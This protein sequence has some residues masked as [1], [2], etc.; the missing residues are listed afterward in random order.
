MKQINKIK[1]FE[2]IK[3]YY[4]ITTCGKIIS[5]N[6][7]TKIL[8]GRLKKNGYEFIGLS[9]VDG[10][11]K[12]IYVHR[13]VASAFI[14]NIENK[15]EVNHKNEI[16]TH[17]YVQNLEWVTKKENLNYGTRKQRQIESLKG[18]YIGEKNPMSKPM[19]YYETKPTQ[20]SHFKTTCKNQGWNFED[21]IEI[22]SG[23]KI[24]THRKYYYIYKHI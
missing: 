13:L 24:G 9:V 12:K 8:K 14:S 2:S 20:R 23:E 17:N 16:K 4:Y 11:Q 15:P 18:K 1:G 6:G 3:D 5:T 10:K 21:F 19:K 7:K 22:D